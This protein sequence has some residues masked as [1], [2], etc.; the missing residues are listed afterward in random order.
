MW[1]ERG[2]SVNI[3]AFQF[4]LNGNSVNIN[5]FQFKLNVQ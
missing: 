2:N 5:D 3:N 4:K 1:G